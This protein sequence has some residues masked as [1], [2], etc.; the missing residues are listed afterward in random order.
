MLRTEAGA[1]LSRGEYGGGAEY[2]GRRRGRVWVGIERGGCGWYIGRRGRCGYG[3][4]GT[5]AI[6][7]GDG[8][9]VSIVRPD[10]YWRYDEP[11][12]LQTTPLANISIYGVQVLHTNTIIGNVGYTQAFPTGTTFAFTLDTT[13]GVTTNSPVYVP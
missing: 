5:G 2:A 8:T 12:A 7:A 4:I 9:A 11:A 6:D 10:D 1:T 3:R 13:I